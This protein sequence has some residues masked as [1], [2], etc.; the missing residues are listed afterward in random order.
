MENDKKMEQLLVS[1]IQAAQKMLDEYQM[2]IP[3]GVK[4][5]LKNEDVKMQCFQEKFPKADW[6]ELINLTAT[7]LKKA[8][9][10]EEL[11]ATTVITELESEGEKGVGIQIE[12][13]ESAVL[14]VYPY[15]KKD[16]KWLID[17]PIQLDVLTAPKIFH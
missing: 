15:E 13:I 2:I 16:D 10:T 14:F 8:V 11:F 4:A 3:F 5:F 1:S 7:E 17:E 12:T 6:Q 9:K